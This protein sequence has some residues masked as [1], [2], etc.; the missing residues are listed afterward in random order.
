[1]GTA[2]PRGGHRTAKPGR[3]Q[4]SSLNAYMRTAEK[5]RPPEVTPGC[6]TGAGCS[7]F[8]LGIQYLIQMGCFYYF[9][10]QKKLYRQCISF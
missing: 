8:F 7:S 4:H 6:S 5:P 9:H 2:E 1:M 3:P 10:N